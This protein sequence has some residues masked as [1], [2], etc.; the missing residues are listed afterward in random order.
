[1]GWRLSLLVALNLVVFLILAAV[2]WHGNRILGE[3]W[4]E[5]LRISAEERLFDGVDSNAGTLQG[6]IHRYLEMPTDAVLTD[7]GRLRTQLLGRLAALRAVDDSAAGGIAQVVKASQRLFDGFEALRELNPRIRSLYRDRILGIG[8][9]ISGLYGLLDEASRAANAVSWASISKSRENFGAVLLAIDAFYFSGDAE[10]LAR[11]RRGLE[12][13]TQ[14]V[15]II[16]EFARTELEQGTV[17]ALAGRFAAFNGAL[18]DLTIDRARQTDLLGTE[19]DGAQ[20]QLAAT[21]D[22]IAEGGRQRQ[23][24]AQG[25]YE[26]AVVRV[27]TVVA[28]V[29]VLFISISILVS[30]IIARSITRPLHE[31]DRVSAAVA[32][33]DYQRPVAGQ[34]ASDQFGALA[35]TLALVRDHA[36]TRDRMEREREAHERRWRVVL[37]TSPVGITIVAAD[38]LKRLYV[39]P[40]FV[41]QLGLDSAE[42]ALS[43]T[44]DASYANPAEVPLLAAQARSRGAIASHEVERR[45]ADGSVWWCVMHARHIEIDGQ[46]AFI[47]WHYDITERRQAEAALREAKERA[48]AA[49]ADLSAVQHTLIQSEKMASLGGLVAGVAHEINTP[50]GISLTSASL[51]AEE[52]RR[53]SATLE[54]GLLRR[55]DLGRFLELS[56]E[57]SDL[58]VAN[59]QR[60]A[61]L[62]KSFKQVAVDQTSDDRRPFRL[63]EYI[64]EVLMSLRPRLKQSGAVVTVSCP[65]ELMVE[66]YPGPLAQVLTNFVMNSLIH[67]YGPGQS[68]QLGITVICPGPDEVRLVYADD[69]KGIAEEVLPKIFDPFFTTNRVGGGSGLGLN[70]VYNLVTQR[71]GGRIEVASRPGRGTQFTLHFPRVM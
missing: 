37:E 22:G 10:A 67:G 12:A 57:S 54:A 65:E 36:E 34:D 62:I 68:G 11:A 1:M 33:G 19:I 63:S 29:G 49:L 66:G 5:V 55:S 15:P 35:R 44:Y 46:P 3:Q 9:E 39:N 64:D 40:R 51:L 52:S 42:A 43:V 21:I 28:T 17:A 61:D 13:I 14:T 47:V 71:L 45:R 26:D 7:I 27:G 25:R 32:A 31:L 8:S 16:R 59:C 18:T 60:A 4:A 23:T 24:R 41:E 48:E 50:L 58:L 2:I 38:T 53:L 20:S 69:G 56:L 70:I 30:L 6:Q